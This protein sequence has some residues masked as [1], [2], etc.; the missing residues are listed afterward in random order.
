MTRLARM[1]RSNCG[2]AGETSDSQNPPDAVKPLHSSED[3]MNT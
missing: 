3:T 2:A 1:G